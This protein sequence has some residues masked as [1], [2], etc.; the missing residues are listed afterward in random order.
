MRKTSKTI[1]FFGNERLATGVTTTAP[2]LRGLIDGGWEVA[3]LVIAQAERSPSRRRQGLEVVDIADK[4][5]IPVLSPDR[6]SDIGDDLAGLHA[7]T[8]I[9]VAYG[10]MIPQS[11]I[12]LFPA[13]ILNIHPSL[14]PLHRGAAPIE[15]AILDGDEVTGVSLMS[16]TSELDAGPVYA[17]A[18]VEPDDL[19]KQELA[20]LLLEKG[21]GLLLSALPS[22]LDG[23]AA[24]PRPQDGSGATFDK[25]ILKDD[26]L[27]DWHKDA[28]RL[29]REVR[30]Y[31]G[32]PNSRTRLAGTDV[33]ITLAKATEGTSLGP[34]RI[35]KAGK[36][37]V[38][39]TGDGSLEILRLKPAG[40]REM[41]AQAFLAGYQ[42]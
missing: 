6:L 10:K 32:W 34:G 40:K 19:S 39:D 3:A 28:K 41:P 33:I 20:D 13:G 21:S 17:Q 18:R 1:V 31:A 8:A 26:G 9:A 29:E 23:T 5:G 24:T 16:L 11:V 2:T 14:L 36:R 4:N 12:D 35:S 37:L 7:A 42:I 30:A 22:I 25:R 15:S 27:I 38:I